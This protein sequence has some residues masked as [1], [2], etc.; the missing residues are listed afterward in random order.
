[1]DA[2]YNKYFSDCAK[3]QKM[4]KFQRLRQNQLSVDY[5]E[6]MIAELSQYAPRLIEDL[7]D[8]AR[9]FRD[10]HVQ[11]PFALFSGTS[12]IVAAFKPEL[13]FEE[14]PELAEMNTDRSK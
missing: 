11:T 3:E 12:A 10:G 14:F 8:K 5:Y 13:K 2:F 9:R 4:N 1:M 7:V 6:A